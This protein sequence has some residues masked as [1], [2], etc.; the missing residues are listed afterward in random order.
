LDLGDN[1]FATVD[2]VDAE[3]ASLHDKTND[4]IDDGYIDVTFL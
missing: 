4:A 1:S 2:A 3:M